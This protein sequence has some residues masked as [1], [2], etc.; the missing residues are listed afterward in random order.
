MSRWLLRVTVMLGNVFSVRH[1]HNPNHN[2]R[3]HYCCLNLLGFSPVPVRFAVERVRAGAGAG[4]R[5]CGADV[6][7]CL[8]KRTCDVS[9]FRIR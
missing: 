6:S 2:N 8:Y 1:F 7:G 4:A 3:D 5:A 9:Y